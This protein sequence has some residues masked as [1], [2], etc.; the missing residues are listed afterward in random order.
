MKNRKNM[1][2]INSIL[3]TLL[4]MITVLFTGMSSINAAPKSTTINKEGVMV[5]YILM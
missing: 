1:K 4:M 2:K 3:C 5:S